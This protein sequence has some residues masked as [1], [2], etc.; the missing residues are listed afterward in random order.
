MQEMGS[1]GLPYARGEFLGRRA[2][3][4]LAA[5]MATHPVEDRVQPQVWLED[6]HVLVTLADVTAMGPATGR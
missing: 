4:D 5:G 1:L 6:D 2:R 3:R